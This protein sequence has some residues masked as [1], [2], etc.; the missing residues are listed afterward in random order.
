MRPA[1]RTSS[2]AP[3]ELSDFPVSGLGQIER[4][5]P[6]PIEI[7]FSGD[8]AEYAICFVDMVNSTMIS[9]TLTHEELT[10]YYSIFLNNIA[11]IV[12]KHGGRVLKNGGDA[13][14]FCFKSKS[15]K[16]EN[17]KVLRSVLDCGLSIV[18]AWIHLNASTPAGK[19]KINYR[20]SA[21]YGMVNIGKSVAVG[22]DDL[23]GLTVNLCAKINS[24]APLNGMV[25]GNSL[26]DKVKDFPDY[27]F[28][29][30]GT[31]SPKIADKST[32]GLPDFLKSGYHA[33][34]VKSATG[35]K[36]LNPFDPVR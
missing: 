29:L 13:L 23:F 6:D 5:Q 16:L 19:H 26:Y 15:E 36:S 24:M 34:S 30:V 35:K 2:F 31:Y 3:A 18:D 33:F 12:V 10:R 11:T 22:S 9:A 20:V 25:I 4:G 17:D 32:I 21:D 1:E 27:E 28:N 8:S 7:S 14:I